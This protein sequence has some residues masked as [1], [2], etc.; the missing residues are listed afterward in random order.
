MVSK[1]LKIAGDKLNQDI[2]RHARDEYKLLIGEM[3]AEQVK[4]TIGSAHP[5]GE[6][7]EDV[8][9]GRDLISGLPKE[10]TVTEEEIRKALAP[11][12][13]ALVAAVKSAVEITPPELVSDLIHNGIML[14]G[15][16][17]LLRGLDRR[18]E[19][20]TK[21]PVHIAE[22]PLTSVV[23]GTGI[24]LENLEMFADV[25]VRSQYEE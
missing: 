15:G 18:I 24:I 16:G 11:S 25:L 1:T 19:E 8:I 20:E 10:V 14:T 12:V 21:I 9:S 23:I 2:V 4:I 6:E 3:A 5:T 17:S 13:S 22:D 7:L